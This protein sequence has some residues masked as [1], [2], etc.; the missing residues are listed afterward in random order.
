[1]R[2]IFY[3]VLKQEKKRLETEFLA[4]KGS[5][6]FIMVLFSYSV[7]WVDIS[8]ISDIRVAFGSSEKAYRYDSD[9]LSYPADYVSSD[10]EAAC[11]EDEAELY[12][13]Q[14]LNTILFAEDDTIF[15]KLYM[16][17]REHLD[18]IGLRR[19]DS[20]INK[21]IQNNYETYGKKL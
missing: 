10:S 20:Y 16:E 12:A 17:F 2:I 4:W 14:M 1:M 19:Y 3:T 5:G 9:L 21:I 7:E 18:E 11:I 6:D 15:E 13:E 8:K